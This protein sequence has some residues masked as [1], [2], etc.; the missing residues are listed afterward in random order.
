MAQQLKATGQESWR[1]PKQGRNAAGSERPELFCA[2]T[3]S[4]CRWCYRILLSLHTPLE[5][6]PS[7]PPHFHLP[8]TE[9]SCL[10]VCSNKKDLMVQNHIRGGSLTIQMA[11]SHLYHKGQGSTRTDY[12]ISVMRAFDNK[13][14]SRFSDE[15]D[16][17]LIGIQNR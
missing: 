2:A 13:H 15:Y 4:I 16:S 8:C 17:A 14:L 10:S 7:T 9:P 3:P 12:R 5:A 1:G 6:R 11:V